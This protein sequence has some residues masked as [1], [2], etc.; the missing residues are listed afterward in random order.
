ME[1][2]KYFCVMTE[3]W[4][5][6]EKQRLMGF[7]V[8]T[9]GIWYALVIFSI[10]CLIFLSGGRVVLFSPVTIFYAVMLLKC[11]F[12]D[13]GY[14]DTTTT[15]ALKDLRWVISLIILLI[16][17]YIPFNYPTMDVFV[18]TFSFLAGGVS[19]YHLS[20]TM[21]IGH[22]LLT[23]MCAFTNGLLAIDFAGQNIHPGSG[24]YTIGFFQY[25]LYVYN[26]DFLANVV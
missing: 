4:E 6:L 10:F 23:L 2:I 15:P 19:I 18:S 20:S 8:F 13:D 24:V 5:N 25:I 11:L 1:T 21:D 26:F 14:P 17:F 3:A 16:I 22:G 12:F 9:R 7:R